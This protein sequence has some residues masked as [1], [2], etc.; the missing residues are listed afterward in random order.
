MQQFIHQF[1]AIACSRAGRC[2]QP[3]DL[4]LYFAAYWTKPNVSDAKNRRTNITQGARA[5]EAEI[6]P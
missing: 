6:L 3:P 4:R 1:V 2:P 5:L